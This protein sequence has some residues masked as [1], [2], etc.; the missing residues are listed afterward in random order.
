MIRVWVTGESSSFGEAFEKYL[1]S[2]KELE[3]ANSPKNEDLDYFRSKFMGRKE[4]DCFDPTL[5]NLIARSGSDIILFTIPLSGKVA[6][7]YPDVALRRNIEGLYRILQAAQEINIPLVWVKVDRDKS[8]YGRA[9]S[10]A[11][12]HLVE[13]SPFAYTFESIPQNDDDFPNLERRILKI[14]NNET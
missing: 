4:I 13:E 5:P 10:D 6:D 8:V 14:I 2:S 12:K 9:S 1:S 7:Q 11:I 3:F